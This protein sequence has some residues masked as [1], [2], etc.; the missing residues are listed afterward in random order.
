MQTVVHGFLVGLGVGLFFV[1]SEY[2][3]LTKAVNDRAKRLNRKA[4]FDVTERRRIGTV[5]RFAAVLPFAF[6]T[7]FWLV[8][9]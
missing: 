1:A 6:A 3:L 4:E 2:V 7:V 5:A 9:D 8:F